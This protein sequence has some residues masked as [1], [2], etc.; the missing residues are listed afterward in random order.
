MA[1]VSVG[2]MSKNINRKNSV[3]LSRL[4]T[5]LL[6]LWLGLKI[7]TRNILVSFRLIRPRAFSSPSQAEDR[8]WV[9]WGK[10]ESVVS[11][12]CWSSLW[13][14]DD[15]L[16][17]VDGEEARF[18]V[19]HAL[20]PVLVYLVGEDDDVALLEAQLAFVLWLEVVEGATARLVQHLWLCNQTQEEILKWSNHNFTDAH[21]WNWCLLSWSIYTCLHSDDLYW[22]IKCLNK[23]CFTCCDKKVQTPPTDE[24]DDTWLKVQKNLVRGPW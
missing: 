23:T 13:E 5:K 19:D 20:I 15:D 1:W 6:H 4:G 10:R 22:S 14:G 21:L 17:V 7:R 2:F 16:H 3:I 12:R 9:W 24:D 11:S 8:G 18:A